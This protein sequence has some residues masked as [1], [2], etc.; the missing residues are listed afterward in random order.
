MFFILFFIYRN[1]MVVISGWTTDNVV[2]TGVI[3]Y[4]ITGETCRKILIWD[5]TLILL[6]K[7]N[8][9]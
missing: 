2:W 7:Q 8:N 6:F 3:P 1:I 5:D 4:I 9:S